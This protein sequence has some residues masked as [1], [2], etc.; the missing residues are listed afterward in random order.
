MATY[1]EEFFRKL[2]ERNFVYIRGFL[3][4]VQRHG[5]RVALI[6]ASSGKKWNYVQ[7]NAEANRFANALLSSGI[8][9]QDVVTYQLFNCPEFAF[10]YLGCQKIGAINNPINFRFSPQEIAHIL[11]DSRSKVY[12]FD[13]SIKDN[14]KKALSLSSHKPEKMIVVGADENKEDGFAISYN[15]FVSNASENDPQDPDFFG[16]NAYKESTR[17]YTSG[18]TGLPKGVPLNNI[19]EIMAIYDLMMALHLNLDDVMLNISPWFHRG[20]IHLGGPCPALY[21]GASIVAMKFFYPRTTLDVIS[22]YNVTFVVGVPTMYKLLVEEQK[23]RKKDL[24]KLKG[25]IAMGSPLNKELCLEMQKILTPNIYN[26]YGTSET[27]WNTLLLPYDL[28]QHAGKIGRACID[29]EVRVVKAYEDRLAEPDDIVA[30]DG[31]EVGEIII[32]TLKASYDYLHKPEEVKHKVYR[33]WFYTGDMGVWDKDGYIT[34]VSRKDDMIIVGGE[35]IYP[36]IIEAVIEKHPKVMSCAVVG[37]PDPDRGEALAAY[38]VKKDET[39][40][41]EEL[42]AFIKQDPALS[43]YYRP[44]YYCFV[45]ELPMTATGKKQHYILRQR[46]EKDLKEKRLMR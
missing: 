4:N 12:I 16:V 36:T 23:K 35:N 29:D 17:L 31:Q 2:F 30:Q 5:D 26:G 33:D 7:L 20:G 25:A 24:S 38:V 43:Q 8:S 14:V 22:K 10:I 9:P 18:T 3:R 21:V 39:L 37:V 46:A 6:D 32:K 28:P 11:E 41:V 40:T 1:N 42:K 44:R 45:E 13:A 27:F 34:V 19:N 15:E